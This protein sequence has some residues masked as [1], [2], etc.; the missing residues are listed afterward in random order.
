MND[1]ISF[2]NWL[3][4]NLVCPYCGSGVFKGECAGFGSITVA[5]GEVA[6]C[7][8]LNTPPLI[9]HFQV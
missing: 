8:Q 6:D 7:N 1:Y 5:G 9:L 2:W 4:I 3:L